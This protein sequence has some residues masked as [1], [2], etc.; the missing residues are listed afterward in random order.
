[1]A[2]RWCLGLKAE[3]SSLV[4]TLRLFARLMQEYSDLNNKI[5]KSEPEK[6]RIRLT[7]GTQ[8]IKLAHE[9]NFRSYVTSEH[10][11]LIARLIIV[12]Q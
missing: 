8:M 4:V 12:S 6:A 1:M 11:H 5:H 7:C 3:C 10:F 9:I 2:T